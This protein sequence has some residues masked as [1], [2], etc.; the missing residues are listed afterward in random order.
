MSKKNIREHWN[1]DALKYQKREKI[2]TD[3]VHYG[4]NCPYEKDLNLLGDVQGKKI[5]EL[6]CGGGQCSIALTKRGAICTGIDLS[7]E[8]IKYAKNL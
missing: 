4:P 2:S 5:V 1:M 7:D 8:Q 6:G 3:H